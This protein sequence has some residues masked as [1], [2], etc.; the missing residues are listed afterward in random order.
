MIGHL[1]YV[2]QNNNIDVTDFMFEELWN[3]V[4]EKKSCIYA[5]FIQALIEKKMPQSYIHS[6]PI[7]PY[8]KFMPPVRD[9]NKTKKGHNLRLK[10]RATFTPEV[11]STIRGPLMSAPPMRIAPMDKNE[12]NMFIHGFSNLLNTCKA[13]HVHGVKTSNRHKREIQMFKEVRI[14]S[15]EN[16]DP[17]SE[18]KDSEE[19]L[20]ILR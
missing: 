15:G 12:K 16:V 17:G 20:Q 8:T 14:A 9:E 5:P 19:V 11:A 7:K 3:C 4:F 13:T 6:L 1:V 2:N 18:D 10:D